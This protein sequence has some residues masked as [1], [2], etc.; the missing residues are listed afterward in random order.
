MKSL[1][2]ITQEEIEKI[3]IPNYVDYP[4]FDYWGNLITIILSI[5]T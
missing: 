1:S 2:K 5:G 4:D 3:Y